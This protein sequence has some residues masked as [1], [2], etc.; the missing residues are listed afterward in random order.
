MSIY[1][2]LWSLKFPRFGDDYLGCEWI[3]VTAQGVPPHIGT[4]TPGE[5]YEDGDPYAEFLPP[6]V[7]VNADGDGEFMRAVVIVTEETKKGTARSGQEYVNPLL[8]LSGREYASISFNDLH[9]RICDA[10]RGKGPRVVAQ[11]FS[12]DG[13]VQL[14]LSD[15]RIIDTRKG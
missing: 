3:R 13:G 11:S 2:T 1:A 8:V 14:I 4:P 15:G 7:E 6:P 9:E 10:L 5:G 12:A